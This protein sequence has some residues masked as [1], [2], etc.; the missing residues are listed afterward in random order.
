MR[1]AAAVR[2]EHIRRGNEKVK[3]SG[4][5]VGVQGGTVPIDSHLIML[6]IITACELHTFIVN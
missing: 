2:A 5:K 1:E 4:I 3:W 6:V